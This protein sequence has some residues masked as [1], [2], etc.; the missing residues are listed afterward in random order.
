MNTSYKKGNTFGLCSGKRLKNI[1]TK[2]E[3]GL[4]SVQGI[5]QVTFPKEEQYYYSSLGN[6]IPNMNVLPAALFFGYALVPMTWMSG[7]SIFS[8][9][10]G[11]RIQISLSYLLT[12]IQ[13]ILIIAAAAIY[14]MYLNSYTTNSTISYAYIHFKLIIAVTAL[15]WLYFLLFFSLVIQ[16]RSQLS[17][18]GKSTL[19]AFGVLNTIRLIVSTVFLSNLG[20]EINLTIYIFVFFFTTDFLSAISMG[21]LVT[22]YRGIMS[23]NDHMY[24]N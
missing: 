4:K 21:L 3:I 1:L 18:L 17:G 16:H 24:D 7:L 5:V 22:F 6:S 9:I 12:L 2:S 20:Y 11:K 19:V 14:G 13:L 8:N 15:Q 23:N 10:L